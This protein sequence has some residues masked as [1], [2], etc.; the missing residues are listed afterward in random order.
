VEAVIG[1]FGEKR[2]TGSGT[3]MARHPTDDNKNLPEL[4]QYPGL[5]EAMLETVQ[6]PLLVL[7]GGLR[8][9]RANAAFFGNFKVSTNESIGRRLSE[10]GNGQWDI[11][12]LLRMLKNVRSQGDAVEGYRVEHDFPTLGLRIMHLNA[13]RII[14]KGPRPDLI[15]LAIS[16]VTEVE[17]A[18]SE[19]EGQ[20]EYLD[21]LIDSLRECLVVLDWN[22]RLKHANE[23][24][25][26]TFEV[27]PAETEGRLIYELGNG[28]WNIPELRKL[29]EEILPEE[30]SFDDFEVMHEFETIGYRHM[31]LNARRLD[32][33]NLIVL[34][35]EDVTERDA[36][37]R[38]Q[39]V[40]ASEMS[41]RV[42]NILTLVD[43][44]AAQ[45][46]RNSRSLDDFQQAFHGRLAA[47]ARSH[48]QWLVDES[49]VADLR[50]LLEDVA[51]NTGVDRQR[52]NLQG[53]SVVVKPAQTMALNL[54]V[55]ELCTNA[56]KYGSLATAT[57]RVDVTWAVADG[58]QVRLLWKE[59]AG[60]ATKPPDH[61]GFGL[62]LIETLCPFELHGTAEVRFAPDGLECELTFPIA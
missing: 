51:E 50:G 44:I 32:H 4:D 33:L 39:R 24:F 58:N 38:R 20:R 59:S 36:S 1:R 34:A 8:L 29:L 48:G 31:L 49:Q 54:T 7:N 22:L 17:K 57:G 6:L 23:P 35:I 53:P 45:T 60:P 55:H 41:H 15:L 40:L 2:R 56:I 47:L 18:R 43:S 52:L 14:A 26:K 21:K 9:I 3:G 10:L 13:R 19:L 5:S 25:Y 42:K 46:A 16:D 62:Q 61:K 27:T 37:Y 11:P 30:G 28:Q 12:D